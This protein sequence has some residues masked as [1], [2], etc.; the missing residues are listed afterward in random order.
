MGSRHN[1]FADPHFFEVI[2]KPRH[3]RP[4]LARFASHAALNDVDLATL[5]N[6]PATVERLFGVF[7]DPTREHDG[8][9]LDALHSVAD[10]ANDDAEARFE[11]LAPSFGVDLAGVERQSAADSALWVFLNAPTLFQAVHDALAVKTR[12]TFRDFY[13]DEPL[14]DVDLDDAGKVRLRAILGAWLTSKR[15]PAFTAIRRVEESGELVFIFEHGGPTRTDASVARGSTASRASWNPRRFPVLRLDRAAGV[16]RVSASHPQHT[17]VFAD[18]LSFALFERKEVF[19]EFTT[20]RPRYTLE[21]LKRGRESL[22]VEA[23][24]G[25]EYATL[26]SLTVAMRD[27]WNTVHE[28]R[29]EDVFSTLESRPITDLVN[30]WW[31]AARIELRVKGEPKPVTVEVRAPLGANYHNRHETERVIPFLK[32]VGILP[33]GE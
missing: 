3:L 9:L 31:K 29:A 24:E 32:H 13:C 19:K 16:L 25:F 10:V 22:D 18:A 23:L 1:P 4:L 15:A 11:E 30:G 28:L 7:S 5:D 20:E 12:R 33:A 27:A 26:R 6:K 2:D 8:A 17:G 21:P 14:A